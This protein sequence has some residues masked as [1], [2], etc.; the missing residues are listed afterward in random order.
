ML[1]YMGDGQ[2]GSADYVMMAVKVVT[3]SVGVSVVLLICAAPASASV[4]RF[5][6][7]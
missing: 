4:F 2:I 1:M 3:A 7:L 6:T 5:L